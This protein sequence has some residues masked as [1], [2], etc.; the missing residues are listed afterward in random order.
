MA[1]E[2]VYKTITREEYEQLQNAQWERLSESELY[3][4]TSPIRR[5][6]RPAMAWLYF[7]IIGMDFVIFPIL[8]AAY[9]ASTTGYQPFT[10]QG[11][12]LFHIAMGAIVATASIGR[13]WEKMSEYRMDNYGYGGGYGGFGGGGHGMGMGN[14]YS[15]PGVPYPG[16]PPIRPIMVSPDELDDALSRNEDEIIPAQPGSR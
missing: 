4:R 8:H 11:G 10:L 2:K 3:Y 16:S 1:N 7:T 15:D 9:A 12:G 6:W 14:P 13:S 5:Y